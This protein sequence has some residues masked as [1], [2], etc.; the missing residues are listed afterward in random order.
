MS[1]CSFVA[2][3][4]GSGGIS[5]AASLGEQIRIFNVGVL[6]ET[7]LPR[8]SRCGGRVPAPRVRG[9]RGLL[10]PRPR[11]P[12]AGRGADAGREGEGVWM[13]LEVVRNY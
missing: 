9:T 8:F 7:A 4:L 12:D 11:S 10:T 13:P 6:G 2:G 1:E 5:E 3:S